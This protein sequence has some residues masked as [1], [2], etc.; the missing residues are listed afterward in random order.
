MQQIR[1]LSMIVLLAFHCQRRI[2]LSRLL[3]TGP[4]PRPVHQL[5][6]HLHNLIIIILN[7]DEEIQLLTSLFTQ[8]VEHV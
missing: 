5:D 8:F 4:L 1:A 2:L 6:N 7:A 3:P